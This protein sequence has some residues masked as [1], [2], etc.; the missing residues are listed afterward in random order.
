VVPRQ[1]SDLSEEEVLRFGRENLARF[2]VP[3]NVHLRDDLPRNALGKV[4]RRELKTG[5]E[6]AEW[7]TKR[8]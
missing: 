1:G 6:E 5:E 2:K 4:L 7:R 3:R 8:L